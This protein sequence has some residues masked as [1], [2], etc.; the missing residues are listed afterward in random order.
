MEA[1]KANYPVKR[2]ARLLEVSTSGFYVWLGRK[3]AGPSKRAVAGR[4]V[5][6]Q[7]RRVH[8][9]SGLLKVWL[10]PRSHDSWEG[11]VLEGWQSCRRP[12]TPTRLI[13]DP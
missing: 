2:M 10:T 12:I 9:G 3:L 4:D 6:T 5:D 11:I 7:V 1:E 8:T 13:Q